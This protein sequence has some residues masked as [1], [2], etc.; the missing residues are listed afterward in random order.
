[1]K[2]LLFVLLILASC[3]NDI[4]T[5]LASYYNI[6]KLATVEVHEFA[7]LET[8]EFTIIRTISSSKTLAQIVDLLEHLPA[9]GDVFVSFDASVKLHKVYLTDN[10]AGVDIITIIEEQIQTTDGSFYSPQMDAEKDLVEILL[11]K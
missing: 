9:E 8:S 4:D 1:M 10:A 11:G 6:S 7:N 2:N 5:S 3:S